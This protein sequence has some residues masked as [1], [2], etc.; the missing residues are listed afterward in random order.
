[1]LKRNVG[2]EEGDEG[3]LGVEAECIV[4]QVDGVEVWEGEQRGQE[5]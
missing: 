5:R 3:C 1:M 4:V 2:G